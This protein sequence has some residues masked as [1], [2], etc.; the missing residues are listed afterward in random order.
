MTINVRATVLGVETVQAKLTDNTALRWERVRQAVAD[1]GAAL[2]GGIREHRLL[3]Q[4]LNRKTGTLSRSINRRL[5]N[6][7]LTSTALVGTNLEYGAFWELG[8]DGTISVPPHTRRSRSR[9]KRGGKGKLGSGAPI[10]VRGF[11]YKRVALARPFLSPEMESQ[12]PRIRAAIA[13]AVGK[14]GT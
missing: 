9:G 11:S 5:L 3:G 4:S 1:S 14:A 6:T 10:Q 8:F 2:Q 7:T 13:A 12:S